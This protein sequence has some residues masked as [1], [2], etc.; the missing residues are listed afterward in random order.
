MNPITH[1]FPEHLTQALG[2]TLLHS[3][4]Q[5]AFIALLLGLLLV[6][7][8]RHSAKTRYRVAGAALLAQLVLAVATFATYDGITEASTLRAV[9]AGQPLTA[10]TVQQAADQTFWVAPLTVGQAYFEQHLPLLVTFWLLGMLL[11]ALRFT[12]GLAYTQR[13]RHYRATPMGTHWQQ[14]VDALAQRMGMPKAVR[15]VESALVQVPVAI[16]YAKPII[17]L[18]I[19]AVTGLRPEQLEAVLAHE[20]AHILRK[21]Y[22]VNML[23]TA[24]DTL[25]FYHPAMWW[26]SG[27]VRA[28]RENCCDDMAV[29]VC[30][31]TL[32]YARALAQL[33]E[34]RLPAAPAMALAISGKQGSLV[35]RIKRLVGQPNLRPTFTEGFAA[36]LTLVVGLLVLSFGAMAGLTPT[37]QPANAAPLEKRV[38][39]TKSILGNTN[40]TSYTVQDSTGK[41]RDIVIIKNKKGKVKE[42]YVDGKRIPNKYMKEYEA[43]VNQR[44]QAV[45]NGPRAS[46][47][48]VEVEMKMAQAAA[49][50]SK[51]DKEVYIY[52][53]VYVDGD[54]TM[55]PPPPPLPPLPPAPGMMP[56]LPPAPPVAPA[57]PSSNKQQAQKDMER[58]EVEI[59]TIENRVEKQVHKEMAA[60]EK[61]MEAHGKEME[62]RH[63]AQFQRVKAEM[64]NDGILKESDKNL[65]IQFKND[66]FYVNDKKQ[67]KEMAEK[68]RNMLQMGDKKP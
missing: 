54:S 48:E 9:V 1:V 31:D 23:Q 65:N 26:V 39:V 50:A 2:W 30:G 18:P 44:L 36:A 68:Y 5:G 67:S 57:A 15:L 40:V 32:T 27:V 45:K 7:L 53:R 56:P 63:E 49:D 43:L 34:M 25:F 61:A 17:L 4:W 6:L 58:Y 29:A 59:K 13:L 60:H 62:R 21:D 3:L 24:V 38:I 51:G 16:G 47:E 64:V 19:G 14:K 22:L 42:L 12:G 11:M 10:H 55:L 46:R 8:H 41:N 66:E 28:E 37:T 52:K 33:E 20:L 35:N